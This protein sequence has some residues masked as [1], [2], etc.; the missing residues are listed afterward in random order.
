M[1][2][3]CVLLPHFPLNCEVGRN[4]ALKGCPVLVT[5]ASGS[6][7]LVLDYSPG[8][9]GLH[10]DIPLQQALSRQREV[11]LVQA[12]VPYYWSV[13]NGILDALEKIS[14]LV[15]GTDL[16]H[17]CLG[18]DGLQL[19]YRSDDALFGSV[20]VAIPETFTFQMGLAEGKFL[21]YLAA[22]DSPAGG[23]RVMPEDIESFLRELPCQVLPVSEKSKSKLK[24]FGLRTLGQ[25]AALPPG[26]LQAQFGAEGKRIGELARGY[27]DTPLY[28]RL[29]EEIIEESTLLSSVTVSLD[30]LLLTV[31]SLLTHAFARDSLKGRGIS[32][33]TLW[34][35]SWGSEHWER[36]I[37]F[38]EPATDM[39]AVLSRIKPVLEN[40]PQP[41]PVEQVGLKLTRLGY[42]CG[43]QASLFS[44]VRAQDHLQKGVKQLELRMGG[45]QIFKI[46][47]VEP[48]S[49][50]PERRYAL[51]PLSR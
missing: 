18:A 29:S 7:K 4:P 47:E 23:C 35:R 39:A 31:E 5:G 26:P 37:P 24:H 2:I 44:E 34:T 38:K 6:Q 33:I 48:W 22:L 46:K 21:A 8:L 11:E 30:A 13:F 12:D 49:R 51:A 50:I 20:R 40:Y 14:P 17:A 9:E 43:R 27:D 36:N 15:E 45:P 28:P 19:I 32:G 1:K 10:R 3:L 25:V 42:R 16:G 41:G